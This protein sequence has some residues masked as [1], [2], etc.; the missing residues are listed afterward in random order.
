MTLPAVPS[1]E[2]RVVSRD[3]HSRKIVLR[4]TTPQTLTVPAHGKASVLVT[5]LTPGR[6][7][8]DV[9]GLARGALFV[10]G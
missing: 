5:G 6:Y 7:V 1:I 2:L 10:G 4:T 3:G 8:L 9:D